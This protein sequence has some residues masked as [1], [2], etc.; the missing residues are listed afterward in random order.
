M[1]ILGCNTAAMLPYA[2]GVCMRYAYTENIYVQ[3]TVLSEMKKV[4]QVINKYLPKIN[5]KQNR[6]KA[7]I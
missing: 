5:R 1:L 6:Y 7:E 3:E 2:L 4:N